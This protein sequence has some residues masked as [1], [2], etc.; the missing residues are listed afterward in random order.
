VTIDYGSWDTHQ[1]NFTTMKNELLP[2]WDTALAGLLEDL[3]RCGLLDDTLVWSAGEMGRTP[4]INKDAGRDHWGKAMSM[5]LA[6][7]GIKN[8]QVL[9]TTDKQGA[10]VT[11]G[12]VKPEEIAATVLKVLGIDPRTEYEAGGRPITVVR[13]GDPIPA[14]MA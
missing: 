3:S 10:E 12:G 7:G 13:D 8:G 5:M 9:G 6:G 1:R 11:D 14:L 2:T 4:T